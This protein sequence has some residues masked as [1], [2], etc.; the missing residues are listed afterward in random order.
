MSEFVIDKVTEFAGP[1]LAS[2]GLELLEVQFRRE[3]HGWVL[4]L[5]IDNEDEEGVNVDHCARVSREL[6]DYLDVEDVIEYAYHL[7]VSSP[8]LERTLYKLDDFIR[9]TGRKARVK[10]NESL[11][12][13]RVFVGIIHSIH[14]DRIEL[15]TDDGR[16]TEFIYEQVKKARLTIE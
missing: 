1:L 14:D 9:F 11:D 4:R 15:V 12:G 7:E 5:F 6:S 10:L 3:G 8:G 16:I 2:M 13:K